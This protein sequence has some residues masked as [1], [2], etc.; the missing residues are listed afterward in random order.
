M[1]KEIGET[2]FFITVKLDTKEA[3]LILRLLIW[4]IKLFAFLHSFFIVRLLKRRKC[5][6]ELY[7]KTFRDYDEYEDEEDFDNYID[8]SIGKIIC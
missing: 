2:N 8:E 7:V 4:P 5:D 3:C 1:A 6:I